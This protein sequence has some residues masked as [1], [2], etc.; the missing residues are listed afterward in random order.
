MSMR[1]TMKARRALTAV[2]ITTGLALAVAGCGGNSGEDGQKAGTSSAPTAKQQPEAK[3][4]DSVPQTPP[5]TET[6]LAEVKGE[7]SIT[8]VINSA[9]R[10]AGGFVTVNGK[11]K[12]GSGSTWLAQG[13]QGQEQELAANSASVAGAYLLDKAG[14]KKYL[15]L[16]DTEGRCLCTKFN[17]G[18]SAGEERTFFAQFPAPPAGTTKVDFQVGAMPPAA[19]EISEGE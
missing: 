11:V 15:I 5:A 9:V 7:K 6:V 2:A 13:W 17:L 12:N 16:R 19:I 10:D 1:H 18:F 4:K 8:L 14:K 3:P